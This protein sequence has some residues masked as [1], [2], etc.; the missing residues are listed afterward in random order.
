MRVENFA[1]RRDALR[2]RNSSSGLRPSGFSD[3]TRL[4]PSRLAPE[5]APSRARSPDVVERAA[6]RTVRDPE[7]TARARSLAEARLRRART[8]AGNPELRRRVREA[9]SRPPAEQA[10]VTPA[11]L[12]PKWG[13]K[14]W[15]DFDD[16]DWDEFWEE[17]WEEFFDEFDD[18]VEDH[19]WWGFFT[20]FWHYP[21]YWHH[22]LGI[23]FFDAFFFDHFWF[24]FHFGYF[25]IYHPIVYPYYVHYEPD[26]IVVDDGPDVIVVDDGGSTEVV[27]E[28]AY[29]EPDE[30]LRIEIDAPNGA[31]IQIAPG[32]T[33]ELDALQQN[34]A[35]VTWLEEGARHF[36]AGRY[37]EAADAF[38]QAMLLEPENAVPKFALA[39]ALFALGDYGNAAFLIRRGMKILPD[40]PR[41]GSSLHELY[42]KPGDL[43]EHVLA[44]RVYLDLHPDDLD[45]RFLL[46]YVAF[47]TGDLDG[48]EAAFSA[49]LAANPASVEAQAFLERIAEIR[50]LLPAEK[51][52][53]GTGA[54]AETQEGA[55]GEGG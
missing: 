33:R 25:P 39:H 26:V 17:Y 50:K 22:F 5:A 16:T 34:E 12:D 18:F 41:E 15:D 10:P 13:D 21:Y 42:G 43:K 48:A 37:A 7:A 36:K 20:P 53:E 52:G 19:W 47:F 27:Y 2:V 38:R 9:L 32:L 11:N 44:L 45:A 46:G 49:V 3:R 40:W 35:A 24:H 31:D 4:A 23:H 6:L 54:P 1:E 29:T 14:D 55:S 51:E 8:L 28:P 30:A